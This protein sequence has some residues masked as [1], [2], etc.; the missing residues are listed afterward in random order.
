MVKN[1]AHRGFSGKYPENTL[2]AFQK[3]IEIGVDGIELDV[4]LTKDG[5]PVIMHDEN[6]VRTTGVNALIKDLSLDEFRLL[7]AGAVM[8][9][10]WGELPPPTLREYFELI[11]DKNIET[12]IELKT[13]V[14]EY[15]GI[16][17]KVLAL[18]DEFDLRDKIIIS[19]FNHYSVMKFKEIAP[20]IKVGFLEESWLIKP[21]AYT[22]DR[23]AEYFHPFFNMLNFETLTDLR[24]NGIGIN[25]WTVNDEQDM[26][27]AIAME[28]D[29]VIGNYPD[30]FK[31]IRKEVTGK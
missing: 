2:L 25:T 16:E 18:I 13:G 9:G 6:T 28:L 12:N 11:R 22:R 4:H 7:N 29:S 23:G 27:K 30:K 15:T 24:N 1:F 17:R 21:G 26:R 8:E 3:A 10:D 14:Y 5:I 31:A 20:D 19:S